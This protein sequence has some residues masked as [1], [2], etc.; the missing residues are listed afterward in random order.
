[1]KSASTV[2]LVSFVLTAAPLGTVVFAQL[3][4][5]QP[6]INYSDTAANDPVAG[7]LKKI[8][9]NEFTLKEDSK[10]GYLTSL[11]HE[12][13][14]PVSSQTLVFSKT[15]LQR[16]LISSRN[17]RAIYFN[18]DTYVGWVPDGELIEIASVDPILGTV[19][20]T[21]EQPAAKHP[22]VLSRQN[23][24][25][26]FCHAST[27]TGRVPGLL[28]QS[29]YS[30]PNGDRVFPADSIPTNSRG[31]LSGRW[32]GWFVTGTHGAQQHLGNL[33]IGSDDRVL[34]NHSTKFAEYPRFVSLV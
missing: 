30:N 29:V 22:G 13:R 26:L 17:P 3:S 1:M 5:E 7:L 9:R 32:A 15:S 20:Y 31:P 25:C 23:D 34:H 28:M 12:L 14:I 6:P 21:I 27:D 16:H 11:L 4:F 33:M 24:R 8:D 2:V 19:F 18:D 10:T